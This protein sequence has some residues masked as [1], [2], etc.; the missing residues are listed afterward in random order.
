MAVSHSGP[1]NAAKID[2]EDA[3][4]RHASL[5]V[6][7]KVALMK[8]RTAKKLTQAELAQKMNVK[9]SVIT[10]YEAGK[11]IP[12]PQVRFKACMQHQRCG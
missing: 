9:P 2:A 10:D 3:D 4:F 5:G 6:D 1:A 11:V 12:N 8:A 7:F